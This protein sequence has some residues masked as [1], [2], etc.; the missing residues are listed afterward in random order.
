M[1]STSKCGKA[2]CG[3]MNRLAPNLSFVGLRV[4]SSAGLDRCRG[5]GELERQL[6]FRN[7][8]FDCATAQ[9]HASFTST[10]ISFSLLNSFIS[11]ESRSRFVQCFVRNFRNFPFLRLPFPYL[12]GSVVK[13]G[14]WV[15]PSK[16]TPSLTLPKS[17]QTH[18]SILAIQHRNRETH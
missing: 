11:T 7:H 15:H 8:L 17:P 13:Y 18:P 2:K 1:E 12:D 9:T 5:Y 10:R 16:Q 4:F 14:V 3:S 6:T